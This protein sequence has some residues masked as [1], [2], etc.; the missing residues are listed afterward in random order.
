MF[1]MPGQKEQIEAMFPGGKMVFDSVAVE[2][3]MHFASAG[4][5]EAMM[6]GAKTTLPAGI[7][8]GPRTTLIGQFN[9]IA[10]LK[11]MAGGNPGGIPIP[12]A[13]LENL[14]PA[15]TAVRF[16]ADQNENLDAT[17]RIPLKLIST[18]SQ[19]GQAAA[20]AR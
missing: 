16:S 6:D 20:A 3:R 8:I 15:G 9:V 1:S 18:F 17:L 14:D 19:A 5:L 11:Q 13:V 12:P 2:D 4:K 10:M 7:K